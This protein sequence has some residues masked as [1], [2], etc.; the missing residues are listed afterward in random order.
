MKVL[1]TGGAGYIGS[2]ALKRLVSQNHDVEV[3]DNFSHGHREAVPQDIPIHALDIR[4]TES[5]TRVLEAGA[6]DCVMHFAALA[7]VAESV[8]DPLLYY[9]NN[10]GGTISLLEAMQQAKIKKMVFSSTAAVY[11]SPENT[12]IQEKSPTRPINPYGRT[13]RI[14]ETV[15]EDRVGQGDEF[16]YAA[17]RYFNVAGAARDGT[18][19]ED[20][21]PETHLIP[22][23][24]KTALGALDHLT[25]FGDDYNTP[26]GTCIRDYIHVE[27]LVDAHIRAMESLQPGDQRTYNLGIGKGISVTQIIEAARD[28]TGHPIPVEIG[29]RRPG[30]PDELW[31]DPSRI[32]KE[33]GWRAEITDVHTMIESAWN[34]MRDHPDGYA[35]K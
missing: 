2:H 9:N 10:V 4:D 13:K 29:P 27:D 23:T 22:N 1:I 11:G 24:L 15:L 18:L 5:L 16:A 3:V 30:D 12:P 28:V 32:A 17:L 25:L 33:L 26:D 20:H 31:A 14:I 8:A 21:T 6:Y 7:S 35:S 34:W 19:G